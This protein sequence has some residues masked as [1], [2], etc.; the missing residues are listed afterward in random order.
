MQTNLSKMAHLQASYLLRRAIDTEIVANNILCG[1]SVPINISD[2]HI[3]EIT[4]LAMN[5]DN[6]CTDQVAKQRQIQFNDICKGYFRDYPKDKESI[7]IVGATM[8]EL[9]PLIEELNSISD[10]ISNHFNPGTT[11]ATVDATRKREIVENYKLLSDNK[12]RLAFLAKERQGVNKY[13]NWKVQA[14]LDADL[15]VPQEVRRVQNQANSMAN[16]NQMV[17]PI[18]AAIIKKEVPDKIGNLKVYLESTNREMR[19][20]AIEDFKY[21]MLDNFVDNQPNPL[22]IPGYS[23]TKGKVLAAAY[24]ALNTMTTGLSAYSFASAH[25]NQK[26]SLIQM[27]RNICKLLQRTIAKGP[28]PAEWTVITATSNNLQRLFQHRLGFLNCSRIKIGDYQFGYPTSGW[29][30]DF[31]LRKMTKYQQDKRRPI[32][33]DDD[34][35]EDPFAKKIEKVERKD[36]DSESN[37]G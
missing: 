10:A 36:S 15:D 12:S 19:A 6:N 18:L 33:A 8:G 31:N 3:E 24:M 30:F 16:S 22:L 7:W 1:Y 4:S 25:P 2:V 32:R 23:L 21:W 27:S 5:K 11:R 28:S 13:T 29:C 20:G 34:D 14:V 9:R 35:D 37:L 17:L 26:S